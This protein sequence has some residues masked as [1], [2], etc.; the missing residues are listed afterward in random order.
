M[1]NDWTPLPLAVHQGAI[2]TMKWLLR[3]TVLT[4]IVRLPKAVKVKHFEKKPAIFRLTKKDDPKLVMTRKI[5]INNL[6]DSKY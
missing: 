4:H 3:E 6:I 2:D 1:F 5:L